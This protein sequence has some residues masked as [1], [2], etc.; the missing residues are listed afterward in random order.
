MKLIV[1]EKGAKLDINTWVKG[2]EISCSDSLGELFI[3]KGYAI[4]PNFITSDDSSA[5]N[6]VKPTKKRKS[7]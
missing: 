6:Q 5:S 4:D 1:T 3:K 7:K 2:Q